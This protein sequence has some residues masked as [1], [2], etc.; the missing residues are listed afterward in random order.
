MW[1]LLF[2][3]LGGEVVDWM[4]VLLLIWMVRAWECLEGVEMGEGK[5]LVDLPLSIHDEL[6]FP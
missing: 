3:V 1:G 5:G 6:R 4:L 2:D